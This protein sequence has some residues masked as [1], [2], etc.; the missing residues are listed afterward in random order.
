MGK[1]QK[2][3]ENFKLRA[4]KA[5]FFLVL[6]LLRGKKQMLKTRGR[7][8]EIGNANEKKTGNKNM[9]IHLPISAS[10]AEHLGGGQVLG[11]RPHSR[12]PLCFMILYLTC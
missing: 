6:C 10:H 7:D 11:G 4:R 8:A 2:I 1:A 5:M 3:C 9:S 12:P